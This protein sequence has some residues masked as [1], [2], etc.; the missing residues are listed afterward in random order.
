MCET[1]KCPAWLNEKQTTAKTLKK[2]AR[3]LIQKI[4]GSVLRGT[5]QPV[6][7]VHQEEV[8]MSA[9]RLSIAALQHHEQQEMKRKEEVKQ[10]AEP[11]HT[12][13][14]SVVWHKCEDHPA[15]AEK[16]VTLQVT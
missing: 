9:A 16:S 15:N 8:V 10:Q 4:E 7:I 1:N 11:T 3:A 6:R 2:R 13:F 14:T 5:E 12:R